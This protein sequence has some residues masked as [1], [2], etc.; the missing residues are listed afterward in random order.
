MYVVVNLKG[1]V[2]PVNSV[3]RENTKVVSQQTLVVKPDTRQIQ[4]V[5]DSE[6][7]GPNLEP[8]SPDQVTIVRNPT[9]VSM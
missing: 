3:S 4:T 6:E 2:Q 5:F 7:K 9:A 8:K 1:Q